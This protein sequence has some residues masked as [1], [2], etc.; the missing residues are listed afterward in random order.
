MRTFQCLLLAAC[1]APL[2]GSAQT[3]QDSLIAHFPMDGSPNDVSGT[4]VPT[5]TAGLPTFCAD[6]YGN[7]NSAACFDGASFWSYGDVLDMDTSD[8]SLSFW[9]IVD[10]VRMAFQPNPGFWDYG[11]VPICKG[12]TLFGSPVRAGY[13]VQFRQPSQGSFALF[14]VTGDANDDSHYSEHPMGLDTW[15]HVVFSRCDTN[16]L[17]FLDGSL[18]ADS[19]TPADRNLDVNILFTMGAM[20]RDPSNIQDSEFFTGA[21]D[22]VRIFKGRCLNLAEIDTL[23]NDLDLTM[24]TLDEGESWTALTVFPNPV[25]DVI[26]VRADSK[27]AGPLEVMIL[28]ATGRTVRILGLPQFSGAAG[29]GMLQVPVAGLATGSYILQVRTNDQE[30]RGH[31]MKH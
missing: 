26:T 31:F 9:I 16:Q 5:V 14:G 10:T 7:P 29:S 30:V 28:D 4:L 17:L 2:S 27:W 18:V 22:D 24:G 6:R 15:H 21:L 13:S 25:S 3:L 11:A 1:F 12:T 20:N 8:F 23:A 19:I